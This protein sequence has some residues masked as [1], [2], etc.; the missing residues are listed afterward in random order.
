[1]I[2]NDNIFDYV[3]KFIRYFITRA[4]NIFF[5]KEKIKTKIKINKVTNLMD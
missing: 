4:A 5:T 3:I 1:M 2:Q